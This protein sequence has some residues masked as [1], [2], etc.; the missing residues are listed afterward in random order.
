MMSLDVR[1]TL[2]IGDGARQL[3][4]TQPL[5]S[6]KTLRGAAKGAGAPPVGEAVIHAPMYGQ[7][8]EMPVT[9]GQAVD[10]NQVI[11]TLESMKMENR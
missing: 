6:L 2:Q 9:V 10:T 4:A 8:I 3:D 5:A 7:V 1:R 11:V